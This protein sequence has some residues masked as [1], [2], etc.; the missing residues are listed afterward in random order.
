MAKNCFTTSI[1]SW[2]VFNDIYYGPIDFLSSYMGSILFK[3][4]NCEEYCGPHQSLVGKTPAEIYWGR[5]VVKK[6]A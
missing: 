2:F 5:D 3:I 4:K 1:N 6:A